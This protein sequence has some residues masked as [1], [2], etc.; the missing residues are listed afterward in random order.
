MYR[1]L[2]VSDDKYKLEIVVT[3]SCQPYVCGR[4]AEMLK[5]K[6]ASMNSVDFRLKIMRIEK[7]G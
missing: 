7:V 3:W 5:W 1:I 2:C 6:P 4:C